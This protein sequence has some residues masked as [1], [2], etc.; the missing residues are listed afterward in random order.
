VFLEASH[1]PGEK[2]FLG[3]SGR[4]TGDEVI[5]II[6]QQ[7]AASRFIVRKLFAFFA[8]EDPPAPVV[9]ALAAIL[10]E[11]DFQLRP[12]LARLF[13]SAEFYSPRSRASQ[14][15][16]PVQLVVGTLRLLKLD[17]GE[18]P[19]FA[20]LA[21][22]MGQ[23]LFLPPN[24]KGWD[25]GKAWISTSTL[26]DRYNFSSPLL[27]LEGGRPQP[28]KPVKGERPVVR[29]G[30]RRMPRWDP[31]EGGKEVLGGDP[32]SL[33]AGEVVDRVLRRFLVAPVSED[34]KKKLVDFYSGAGNRRLPELIHLVFSSPQYQLD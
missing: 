12:V 33:A 16:S 23:D 18:S 32:Q 19:A 11:N 34:E 13:R 29:P 22:R 1:D 26:F 21:G 20:G 25:G 4:F 6:F 10:R 30:D 8:H 9:E 28:V 2:T 5:D 17:P 31:L 15:K 7:P 27:G 14:I 3:K 24:V